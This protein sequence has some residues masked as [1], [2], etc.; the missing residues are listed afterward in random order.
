MEDGAA[1]HNSREGLA[2]L[3][4][5]RISGRCKAVPFNV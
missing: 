5:V 3:Q 1:R 4:V 2:A